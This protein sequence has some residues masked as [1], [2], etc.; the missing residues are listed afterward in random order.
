MHLGPFALHILKARGPRQIFF[1]FCDQMNNE[2]IQTTPYSALHKDHPKIW[3][4]DL[5]GAESLGSCT[6]ARPAWLTWFLPL[7]F[8]SERLNGEN[9][10]DRNPFD[11][12]FVR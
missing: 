3:Y 7:L 10:P 8:L 6:V 2:Q 12:L 9:P 4:S 5:G 1:F 11:F